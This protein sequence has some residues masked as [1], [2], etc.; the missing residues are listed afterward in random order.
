M[1]TKAKVMKDKGVKLTLDRERTIKFD[2]NALCIL[3][4]ELGDISTAF[5]GLS[6]SDFKTI[7]ILLFAVLAHEE[8]DDFTIKNAGALIDMENI[9]EVVEGLSRALTNSAPETEE[10]EEDESGK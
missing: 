4:D 10:S 3:Q 5:E 7:R 2:L 1:A 6:K 8:N 9:G